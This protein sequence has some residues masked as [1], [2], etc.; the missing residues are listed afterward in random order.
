MTA[1]ILVVDNEPNILKLAKANLV[2]SG[3][4]VLTASDGEGGLRLVRAE[5]PH[6]VLLDLRMQ[7]MSGWDIL[8]ILKADPGLQK[9]PVIVMTASV[10]TN[11]EDRALGAGAAGYLVKPFTIEELL[12]KVKQAIECSERQGDL[13]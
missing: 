7:G 9:T 6:L 3:Y 10:R 13:P 8:K 5:S 12:R 11:Q 2:A 1:R 4:E